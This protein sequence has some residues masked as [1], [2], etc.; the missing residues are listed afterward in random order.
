MNCNITCNVNHWSA[1]KSATSTFQTT[2][3]YSGSRDRISIATELPHECG[4]CS[5]AWTQ[6]SYIVCD[7][8]LHVSCTGGVLHYLHTFMFT[9]NTMCLGGS[10]VWCG[11]WPWM[12]ID[13]L[14]GMICDT[15]NHRHKHSF[16]LKY[17]ITV[18]GTVRSMKLNH[19]WYS[20]QSQLLRFLICSLQCAFFNWVQSGQQ[21]PM[22]HMLDPVPWETVVMFNATA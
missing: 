18:T 5:N 6:L 19:H 8:M 22:W 9:L 16:C 10:E 21:C 3:T 12:W 17:V 14:N 11:L 7:V 13:C 15:V 2:W 4:H 1:K 20:A